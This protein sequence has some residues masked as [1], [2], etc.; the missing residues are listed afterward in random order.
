VTDNL[1]GIL[2]ILTAS[3]AFVLNDAVVKF[4]AAELPPGEILVVR[5]VLAT[6]MLALGVVAFGAARPL[7]VLLTPAMFLRIGAAG[8]ATALIVIA[9]RD[10][11]L[12]TVNTVLQVGP[13]AVTAGAAIVF[14]ERVGLP[15]WL[16]AF[17]GFAGV[18]LIVKPVGGHFGIAAYVLLAA[19][20]CTTTRDL[21]T[22]GLDRDIPSI[23]VA[24]ASAAVVTVGGFLVAPFDDPWTLPSAWAWM[25]MTASAACLFVA[26]TFIIVGMRTGEIAVVAPFRYVAAPL[27]IL[28]G[29]WWWSDMPDALAFLGMGMVIAAGLYI[30]YR[31]RVSLGA[32]PLPAARTSAAP[33]R[34]T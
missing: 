19:L 15:R 11:P 24:A 3:S 29:W 17:A 2:A 26:N 12:A 21:A 5:G 18:I 13:L 34:S 10:L 9:L 20:L 32:G 23:F 27:S 25:L 7:S 1:K 33:G 30:L 16:A 8:A 4:L 14:G 22:R 28:L 31:E 6:A